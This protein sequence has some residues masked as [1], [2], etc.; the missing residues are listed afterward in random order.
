MYI[1]ESGPIFVSE[2]F[3]LIETILAVER[4]SEKQQDSNEGFY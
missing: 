4:L 3:Q 2:V 1:C